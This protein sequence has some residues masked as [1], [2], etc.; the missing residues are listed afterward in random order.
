MNTAPSRCRNH[1]LIL[2][3]LAL[4]TLLATSQNAAAAKL[5]RWIGDD[6]EVSF[7]D[8]PPPARVIS[9]QESTLRDSSRDVDDKATTVSAVLYRV[10]DCQ[11]CDATEGYLTTK[12]VAVESRNPDQDPIIANE[13]IERFG[14]AEVPITVVGEDF[15][16]G[17]S[18]LWLDSVLAKAGLNGGPEAPAEAEAVASG[19]AAPEPDAEEVADEEATGE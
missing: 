19:E 16:K 11:P 14:K 18:P 7:Q 1:R 2:T 4:L 6:G 5:Y 10:D 15:V 3:L 9:F 12:G 17:Y 13:M 8:Q